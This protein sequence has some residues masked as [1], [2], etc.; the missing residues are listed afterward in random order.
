MSRSLDIKITVRTL[1]ERE[2]S[3]LLCQVSAGGSIDP[4][5][6]RSD[7]TDYLVWKADGRAGNHR[8]YSQHA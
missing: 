2:P 1:R 4:F 8:R 5:V 6:Y 3:A 7:G